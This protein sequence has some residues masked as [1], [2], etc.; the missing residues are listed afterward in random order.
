MFLGNLYDG[1]SLLKQRGGR[2]AKRG[3]LFVDGLF[4]VPDWVAA[5]ARLVVRLVGWLVGKRDSQ[6]QQGG[7]EVEALHL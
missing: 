5:W 6:A 3:L 2:L 7:S 4:W 1:C